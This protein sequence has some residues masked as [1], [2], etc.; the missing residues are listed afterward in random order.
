MLGLSFVVTQA[1]P[2]VVGNGNT[3]WYQHKT[4]TTV[5]TIEF[6]YTVY[7][8]TSIQDATTKPSRATARSS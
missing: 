7:G 5:T 1:H 2:T 6:G 4:K 8:T 3:C